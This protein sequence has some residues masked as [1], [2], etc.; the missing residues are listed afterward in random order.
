MGDINDKVGNMIL[1]DGI[2]F[3]FKL[4]NDN[5]NI[6]YCGYVDVNVVDDYNRSEDMIR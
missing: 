6:N 2:R 5:I 1:N 4:C 3:G